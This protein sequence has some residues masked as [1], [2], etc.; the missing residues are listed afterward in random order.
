MLQSVPPSPFK[1]AAYV[2]PY[3]PRTFTPP[4]SHPHLV[5]LPFHLPRHP[6]PQHLKKR[7]ISS[8]LT[9]PRS[10]TQQQS[11]VPHHHPHHH[12][13]QVC[14]HQHLPLQE[15]KLQVHTPSTAPPT[16]NPWPQDS[17]KAKPRPLPTV[18]RVAVQILPKQKPRPPNSPELDPGQEQQ[19]PLEGDNLLARP[20]RLRPNRLLRLGRRRVAR[21]SL[22]LW[23]CGNIIFVLFWGCGF[24]FP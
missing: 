14:P 19:A 9:P 22:F 1:H 17:M 20:E 2:L 18:S 21:V 7:V 3:L 12:F 15:N 16:L 11:Q 10:N 6:L 8:H 23:L 4:K 24:N 5:S 13:L